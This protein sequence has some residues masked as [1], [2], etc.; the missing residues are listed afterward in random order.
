MLGCN[1]RAGPRVSGTGVGERLGTE[2]LLDSAEVL[3]IEERA[4]GGANEGDAGVVGGRWVGG[5]QDDEDA[6]VGFQGFDGT[7]LLVGDP[8]DGDGPALAARV[9]ACGGDAAE[10]GSVGWASVLVWRGRAKRERRR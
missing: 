2:L 4:G 6:E 10:A 5:V 8:V 9:L 1:R 3:G 7:V